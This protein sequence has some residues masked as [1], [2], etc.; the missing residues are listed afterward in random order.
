M[1]E[2]LTRAGV[3][4]AAG[5]VSFAMVFISIVAILTVFITEGLKCI[6]SLNR[7]PT[8]LVA[9]CVAMVISIPVFCAM[10]AFMNQPVEWFMVFAAF[11]ASFV[12]AKVSMS[13]WDDVVEIT[14][15][16]MRK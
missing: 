6:E 10:M 12:A 1:A 2:V 14:G 8:K 5:A 13:G 15:K 3:E 11:L 4:N 9:Y 16:M 7:L